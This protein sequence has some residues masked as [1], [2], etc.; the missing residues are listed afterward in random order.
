M[1]ERIRRSIPWGFLGMLAAAAAVECGVARLDVHVSG[2]GPVCW[3]MSRNAADRERGSAILCFG[4]SLSKEG[5]LPAVIEERTGKRAYNLAVIGGPMPASYFLLR[6]ALEAGTRPAAIVI[7]AQDGP[8]DPS[9]RREPYQ[10]L[11]QEWRNWPELLDVRDCLDLAWS[12]RDAGF[13][14]ATVL[15]K[16]VPSYRTRLEIRTWIRAALGGSNASTWPLVVG[17]RRN[18]NANRGALVLAR[19]PLPP[20]EGLQ[21]LAGPG[22]RS[23]EPAPGE[24]RPSNPLSELYTRR[25][26]NLAAS[27]RIT[28]F[29][30]LPPLSQGTLGKFERGGLDRYLAGVARDVLAAY[31]NVVVIDGWRS[32]YGPDLFPDGIHLD[33]QGATTLS[34]DVAAIIDRS[35]ADPASAPRWV[36]LPAYRDLAA[37]VAL[38]DLDESRDR[39][40]HR[41]TRTK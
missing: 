26:L 31:P 35:L 11:A 32:G 30:L 33:R 21:R 2:M 27:R 22:P 37:R 25:L 29:W 12:A 23:S 19:R 13:F 38:E 18:L 28:V 36:A 15:A 4:T 39:S 8:V 10:A 20:S 14:A 17:L 9:R 7:D 24:P 3:R 34:A 40:L 41:P 5:L 6:R 1:I 16:K